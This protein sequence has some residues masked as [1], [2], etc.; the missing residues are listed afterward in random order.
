MGQVTYADSVP[1]FGNGVCGGDP[2]G[3]VNS[4]VAIAA[5]A[6]GGS[7]VLGAAGYGILDNAKWIKRFGKLTNPFGWALLILGAILS[8]AGISFGLIAIFIWDECAPI[9]VSD[10]LF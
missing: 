8:M 9:H 5:L 6:F 2:I 1:V 3:V 10:I 4:T 7:G